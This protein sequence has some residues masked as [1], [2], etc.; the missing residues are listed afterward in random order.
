[1]ENN[2]VLLPSTKC[3]KHYLEQDI[4]L[5]EVDKL[6]RER[7]IDEYNGKLKEKKKLKYNNYINNYY[8]NH[9]EKYKKYYEENKQ[10][11][12]EKKKRFYENN[13]NKFKEKYIS[14]TKSKK[15]DLNEL[16]IN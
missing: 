6:E 15:D 16:E 12:L 14:K 11:I 9:K 1:M 5:F 10:E 7:L 2:K 4:N 8:A 13:I 3:L